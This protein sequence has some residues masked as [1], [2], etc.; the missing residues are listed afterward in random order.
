MIKRIAGIFL[1]VALAVTF[2]LPQSAVTTF[3]AEEDDAVVM[4]VS[5]EAALLSA[6]TS[7]ET[8]VIIELTSDIELTTAG[9]GSGGAYIPKGSSERVTYEDGTHEDIVTKYIRTIRGNNHTISVSDDYTATSSTSAL[10]YMNDYTELNLYDVTIDGEQADRCIF[11]RMYCTLRLYEGTLITSG[12]KPIST[13]D[14]DG[15]GIY[16][17]GA[18]SSKNS[19]LYMYEGS[20]V[21]DCAGALAPST[22]TVNGIGIYATYANLYLHGE[23]SG[24]SVAEDTDTEVTANV[25]GGAVHLDKGCNAYVYDTA[26]ITGNSVTDRKSV[27]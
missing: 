5:S 3:A 25:Y 18:S 16:V 10:I 2:L 17:V 7:S 19:E 24:C 20:A 1:A 23:I 8:E 4:Y 15:M 12:G 21:T 22:K 11:E 14:R 26:Q 27:V 6:L 9:T 13:T